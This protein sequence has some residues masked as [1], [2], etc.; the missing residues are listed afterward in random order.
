MP[1]PYIFHSIYSSSSDISIYRLII[2]PHYN[3][4]T[5][6]LIALWYS[7]APALQRSLIHSSP[8]LMNTLSRYNNI[9]FQ[10][11]MNLY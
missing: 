9:V 10:T 1:G 5:V 8:K 7:T 6:G 3:Q 2:N 4:L 11:T